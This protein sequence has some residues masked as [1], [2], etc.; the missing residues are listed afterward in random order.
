M[1]KT[2]FLI[3]SGDDG[4]EVIDPATGTTS[5]QLTIGEC[6]EQVLGLLEPDNKAYPMKTPEE[7][8]AQRRAAYEGRAHG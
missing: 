5:G 6:I 4:L 1:R 7:W 8:E 3:R 2:E